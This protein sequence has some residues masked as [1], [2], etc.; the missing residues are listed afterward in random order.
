MGEQGRISP[1]SL[2]KVNASNS[3]QVLRRQLNSTD[4]KIQLNQ[5]CQNKRAVNS[6]P[7]LL[8]RSASEKKTMRK[9]A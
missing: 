8:S 5:D 9:Q 6:M 2:I 7:S 3:V 1:F 4:P